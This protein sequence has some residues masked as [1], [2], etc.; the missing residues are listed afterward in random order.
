MA[1]FD[2]KT[3]LNLTGRGGGLFTSLGTSFGMPSCMLNLTEEALKLIPSPVLNTMQN[4]TANGVNRADDVVKGIFASQRWL[5]G[6]IEFDTDEGR[7]VFGSD[8]SQGGLDRDEGAEANSMGGF[9]DGLGAAAGFAGRLYTNY[10]AASEQ[11]RS[12]ERC[13][14]SFKQFL[15][16]N[17]GNSGAK[18]EELANLDPQAFEDMMEAE[19][20]SAKINLRNAQLFLDQANRLNNKINDILL[21]RA[22]DPGLEPEF[23]DDYAN[24]L[25]GA[26]L[27]IA[28]PSSIA[29][30]TEV[31]RLVYGPP[32]SSF[33][34]FILSKDGLYFDSQ[35]SGITAALTEVNNRKD[36]LPVDQRWK[37]DYDPNLGGRGK[38]FSTND[39]NVYFNTV[40]DPNIIDESPF[41][42]NHYDK[43]GFLQ[44]LIGQ[45]NKRIT[46]VSAQIN[47]LELESASQSIIYNLRQALLSENS[48]HNGK[49]N[50]RKKQVELAIKMPSIYGG[51]TLYS[52]GKVPVNDFSY[53]EG[54]NFLVDINKQKSLVLNQEDI[55]GVVLPISTITYVIPKV[56]TKNTS[57][58]HLL[59]SEMGL[60]SIIYDGSSVSSTNGVI[61]NTTTEIATDKLIAVYNF[62]QTDIEST[63]STSFLLRNSASKSTENYAQLVA[64]SLDT[65]FYRGLGVPYLHG[66][67]KHSGTSPTYPSSLGS[68][69]RLPNTNDFNDFLYAR[70][71][72]SIDFWVHMPNLQAIDDGYDIGDVSGLYR[73][74]LANDNVGFAGTSSTDTENISPKSGDSSVKSLVMG[75]TRDRRLTQKVAASNYNDDNQATQGAFFLAPVQSINAS[76]AGFINRSYYDTETC[77]SGT[78]F[79]SLVHPISSTTG[80]VSFS[81]CDLNFCHV[82]VTFDPTQDTVNVYL[83]GVNVCTSAMSRVFAIRPYDMPNIPSFK[84][85]NSFEYGLTTVGPSATYDLVYGPKLNTYFTPWIVGGGYTDGMY[86]RGNFLGGTNGGVISG[87]KGYIGS[88]KFYKKPLTASEVLNNYNAQ[89]SFFKNIDTIS[90]DWEAIIN[91]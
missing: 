61:L 5:N 6:I 60:G 40:L 30:P 64:S 27:T 32:K 70:S 46:D 80:G 18:K 75:F 57:M 39:L 26:G 89:S 14:G 63:S 88:L 81:S 21:Q 59:I 7:F 47:D 33:G 43:D 49:I 62:L 53:L 11:I 82:A 23:T 28:S 37:F 74:V 31:F 87:L 25:R 15:D 1:V 86:S 84:K 13:I 50:K 48:I 12:I 19:Y 78:E 68:Y 41:F 24:L 52:P 77:A 58:E 71:G 79:H 3:F 76:A 44:D 54:I 55:S 36:L 16:Y 29:G 66:I 4:S 34:Q 91:L 73:L 83:D 67:T 35:I 90:L 42:K 17:G 51:G 72:A 56:H 65:V 9:L 2:L 8:T 45:R 69:V 85:A 10:Q 20:N 22:R 38:G